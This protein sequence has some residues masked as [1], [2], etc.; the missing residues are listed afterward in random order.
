MAPDWTLANLVIQAIT[1]II[2]AHVA[3]HIV[4]EHSFGFVGHSL[5][6]FVA[7][8]LSGYFFQRI[9]NTMVMSTGEAMPVSALDTAAI[10]TLT[11]AGVGG[12][13]MLVIG[14]IRNEMT[15]PRD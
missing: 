2:G 15:K 10:Q 3:A 6:G 7:G 14:F 9:A 4:H 5:V 13:A 1:G 12:I 8:A 11:G